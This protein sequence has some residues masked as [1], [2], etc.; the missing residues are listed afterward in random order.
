MTK[1]DLE[2]NAIDLLSLWYDMRGALPLP[3]RRFIDPLSLRRWM[4]DISVVH[5]HDGPKRFF[6]S[7]HGA[8]VVRHL[9]PT[10]HKKYLEDEVPA[11]ALPDTIKPYD[12]CIETKKPSYSIQRVGLENGLFKSLERMVLPCAGEDP[13][14]IER[15]L[16]WVA[17]IQSNSKNSSSIYKPFETSE[18]DSMNGDHTDTVSDVFTLSNAYI[19]SLKA[20]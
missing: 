17:P 19:P 7:L 2:P 16:V 1:L 12:L 8:N 11:A 6:V 4:G 10:F 13:A 18:M 5:L 9:G 15:F 3:P 14:S 20:G